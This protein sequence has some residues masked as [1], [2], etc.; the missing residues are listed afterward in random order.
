MQMIKDSWTDFEKEDKWVKISYRRLF[1]VY[2]PP[3]SRDVVPE[4]TINNM[5]AK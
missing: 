2:K 5:I 4:L 3:Y 1:T